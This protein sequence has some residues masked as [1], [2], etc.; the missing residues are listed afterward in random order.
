MAVL[1]IPGKELDRIMRDITTQH[2]QIEKLFSELD[3]R[4]TITK[5]NLRILKHAHETKTDQNHDTGRSDTS[6]ET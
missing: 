4:I 5:H 1:R 6:S 2:E 3:F